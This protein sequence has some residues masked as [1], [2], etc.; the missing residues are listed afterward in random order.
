MGRDLRIL[1]IESHGSMSPPFSHSILSLDR[2]SELWEEIEELEQF[3]VG[4]D[5]LYCFLA[6]IEEGENAGEKCYGIVRDD[7]YEVPL[8]TVAAG[9][10]AK[11]LKKSDTHR[12]KA[13]GFYLSKL[14]PDTRC[15]LYWH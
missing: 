15:V 2:R 11:L 6:R 7:P 13:A 8:Q 12:N 10:L 1:P 4:P 9:D 5:G 3:D 14:P